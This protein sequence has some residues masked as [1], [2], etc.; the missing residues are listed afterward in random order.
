MR[1]I[2][3]GID[4]GSNFIKL[5]VG[6]IY[7][8]RINILAASQTP[9]LGVINGFVVDPQ[10][11]ISKLEEAFQKCE[12]ILGIKLSKVV[13]SV[14]SENSEFFLSEGSTTINND[15]HIIRNIDIVRAMQASTYNKI[16]NDREIISVKPTSYY[17]DDGENIKNPIGVEAKK[18]TVKSLIVTIPR[19]NAYTLAK[20][21]EQ[22]GV[23]VIDFTLGVIGDY[24]E[25]QKEMMK[26]NIGIFV[27]IG[28]SKTEISVFNKGLLTNA[29]TVEL[30]SK[31]IEQDLAYIYKLT[32][33]ES[34]EIK[35]KLCAAHTRGTSA[36]IKNKF[37]TK[38]GEE[39]IIS[40]YEATEIAASRLEEIL[41]IVKKQIN[42]LTKKE[43]HYIMI[44]GGVSEMANFSFLLEEVFGRNA[45]I[46]TTKE[47]GV[48]SN[49]YST[50]VGLIKYYEDKL[51][52]RNQEYSIF[53]EE[54]IKVLCTINKKINFGENSILGK[55][56][57]YFFDN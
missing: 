33:K 18:L 46:G 4:I 3:A 16:D 30:G 57:G 31:N 48:R 10:A 34:K 52:S 47:I 35:E 40:E 7:K 24:F 22:I 27:N 26:D 6:E 43:I 1:K 21:L 12:N 55:L 13:L 28:Y 38:S 50:S 9:S 37:T 14:P 29:T 23:E 15:D 49:I 39:V 45:K 19:K 2:I 36:S 53:N 41:K 8:N 20:C 11:L 5:V 51:R 17:I 44:T 42:L 25:F 32:L 54:E 56:F